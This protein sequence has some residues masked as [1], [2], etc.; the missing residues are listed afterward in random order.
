LSGIWQNQLHSQVKIKATF[1]GKLS[2]F[3]YTAVGNIDQADGHEL[4]GSWTSV[5]EGGGR[6]GAL[7]SFVVSW[8]RPKEGF[9]YRSSTSWNGRLYLPQQR[10]ETTWI[11]TKEMDMSSKWKS[12]TINQDSFEKLH[13]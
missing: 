11:L 1:D 2:G 13:D 6:G 12:V 4:I 8:N 10:L 5:L 9:L 7:V 3:Y